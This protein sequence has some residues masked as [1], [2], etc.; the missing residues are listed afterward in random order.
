MFQIKA[1]CN[2]SGC[3]KFAWN[4]TISISFYYIYIY[5]WMF[6]KIVVPPKSSILIRFSIINHPFWDTPIFGNIHMLKLNQQSRLT[7]Q[8]GRPWEN[9]GKFGTFFHQFLGD[10]I[11]IYIWNLTCP[12]KRKYQGAFK[13]MKFQKA[14]LHIVVFRNYSSRGHVHFPKKK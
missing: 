13:K 14:K 1:D 3:I 7:K 8:I 9:F 10:S 4:H 12:L 5:T 6:P 2:S 11:Q